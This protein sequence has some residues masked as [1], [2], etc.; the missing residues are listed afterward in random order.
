MA[1]YI[2]FNMLVYLFLPISKVHVKPTTGFNCMRQKTKIHIWVYSSYIANA[3]HCTHSQATHKINS[4]D[5]LF[6]FTVFSSYLKIFSRMYMNNIILYKNW[7]ILKSFFKRAYWNS[8]KA[9]LQNLKTGFCLL[10]FK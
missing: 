6:V 9:I 3:Q 7:N 2:K 4:S 10:F 1:K 8:L 5:I